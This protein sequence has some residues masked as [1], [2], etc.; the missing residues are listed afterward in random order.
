MK[1]SG[2]VQSREFFPMLSRAI[3]LTPIDDGGTCDNPLFMCPESGC[4][5]EFAMSEELQDHIHFG[6]HDKKVGS[7]SL[8][9]NL[10][11][12]W[13]EKF[14]SVTL[15]SKLSLSTREATGCEQVENEPCDVGWAL[16]NP[17]GGGTR[18]SQNVK[19]YL[20][21]KF[22]LGEE[23]GRKADPAQVAADMR[24]ERNSEGQRKFQRS[25]WLSKAQIQGFFSRLAASKRRKSS[26]ECGDDDHDGLVE[27]EMAYLTEKDRQMT[28]DEVVTEIGLIH[29]ITFD[30]YSICELIK[31]DALSKFNV[32]TLKAICV[33]LDLPFRVKDV[34]AT[35]IYNLK[36]AVKECECRK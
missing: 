5:I 12:D 34:K 1:Y 25:E 19:N 26:Q 4:S 22:D 20:T 18:F 36:E 35:L 17:R 6:Q 31:S 15:E 24:V 29:P 21:A 32:A 13:A 28:V 2:N 11:C 7:E 3:K 16:Q 23:T 30:G 33:Y 14:L 27:E 10:R 8:Y 9:D